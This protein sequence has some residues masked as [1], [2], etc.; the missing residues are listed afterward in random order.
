MRELSYT[1]NSVNSFMSHL[2]NVHNLR[3]NGP[4]TSE[5][6]AESRR[7]KIDFQ[8]CLNAARVTSGI[9]VQQEEEVAV[10]FTSFTISIPCLLD[11]LKENNLGRQIARKTPTFASKD[12]YMM[13]LGKA[14]NPHGRGVNSTPE[15]KAERARLKADFLQRLKAAKGISR[16][17]VQ[18]EEEEKDVE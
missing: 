11:H 7:L 14:H 15:S 9:H 12:D 5:P 17:N 3:N 18:Q 16:I 6:I 10:V 13:H 4:A 8:N 2:A 1:F